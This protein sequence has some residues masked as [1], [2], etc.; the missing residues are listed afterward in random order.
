LPF[1][2]HHAAHLFLRRS[3]CNELGF[4]LCIPNDFNCETYFSPQR[5]FKKV[6]EK[7]SVRKLCHTRTHTCASFFVKTMRNPAQATLRAIYVHPS[8]H[9]L[10]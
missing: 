4:V 2:P 9:L 7:A 10:R 1:K 6:Q 3:H 5:F 8:T